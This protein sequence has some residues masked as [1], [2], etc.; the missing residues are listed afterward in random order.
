MLADFSIIELAKKMRSKEI[1]PMDVITEIYETIGKIDKKINAFIT[2]VDKEQALRI[3]QK[4]AKT[5]EA[6]RSPLFGLPY[7][8]KDAYVTAG[9]RTTAASKVLDDFVPPYSATVHRKL[10]D[11]GAIL[12]GK[13]NM[14]AW[15]H[16][17]S[18]E[19]TDYGV[20]KNPWDI[21]RSPGGSGGGPAAAIAARM[22]SFAIG[23]DTGGL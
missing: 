12:I 16:G 9:V 22:C 23:E 20:T 21:T 17:A 4:R 3:A 6:A 14:D 10:E 8:M 18:T 5:R 13:M 7:V 11:A 1:S 15:G 2:L 19:N